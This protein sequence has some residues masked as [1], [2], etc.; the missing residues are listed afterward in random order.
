MDIIDNL[1][2][3]KEHLEDL[4]V[5]ANR[6]KDAVQLI[7]VSKTRTLEEVR[8]LVDAGQCS[9]GE[10]TV[11]DAL[12]KIPFLDFPGIE[13][14]FIGHLQSKKAKYIPENFHW[15]HAIDSLSLAKKLSDAVV[16]QKS[17]SKLNCLIQVNITGEESKFGIAEK[18]VISFMEKVLCQDLPGVNWRGLMTMGMRGDEAQTQKAFA[19]LRKLQEKCCKQFDLRNFDQLSMG[20]SGDYQLA[21][22]EGATMVR[23]GSKIFG[24]RVYS[25][26]PV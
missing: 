13:W 18:D 22:K 23:V 1:S 14:H 24:Q 20:M 26:T 11:Q 17:N 19:A 7:A 16:N 5:R 21:V 8:L 15:V 10:N 3:V 6:P 25:N 2:T 9:F 4:C 12:T